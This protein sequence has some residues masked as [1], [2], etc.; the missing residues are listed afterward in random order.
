[1]ASNQ[2]EEGFVGAGNEVYE[3]LKEAKALARRYY[4]HTGKPLGVTGEVAEYEAA[5]ILNLELEVAR[6][7]GY[8]ATETKDGVITR[9][10]IKGRYFPDPK[11]RGGRLGGI[12]LRQPFDTVLLVLLDADY[13]AFAIYE[14]PRLAV[15]ALILRPGSKA[16]NERGSVGISQ[17]RAISS[18]RWAEAD[19]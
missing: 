11:M 5:R 17:F 16:R 13:N 12:D 4:H 8:D 19:G 15:E 1:M 18:L 14:A 3:I 10:Q 9:I 2:F 7:A 6:K